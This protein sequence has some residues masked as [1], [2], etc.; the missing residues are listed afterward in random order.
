MS[1]DWLYTAISWILLSWHGVW[2]AAGTGANWSWILAI[3]F[4]VVTLR[5]VLF[6]LFM[7]SIKSQRA[8]Q[9]LAPQITEL[10]AKH[11]SD[12]ETLQREVMA[13]YRKEKANPLGGCLPML[14]QAP[15]FISLY[16]VLNFLNA[17]K[18]DVKYKVLYGWS[19]PQ[20][21]GAVDARLFGAPIAAKFRSSAEDL[22][23]MNAS[24]MT[25]QIVVG[26][27]ALVM[28]ATTYLTTKQMILK[29]GWAAE[30]QQRMIQKLML[31]GFPASLL[32][33]GAIFPLG[34]IIYWVVN[35]LFSLGQQ[36]WVL[37]KYPPLN[38]N[39]QGEV[40]AAAKA[41]PSEAAKALA[42]KPGARP[43][44]PKKNAGKR[45]G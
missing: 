24:S 37:K 43:A 2:D 11:K 18:T 8:M 31:Y 41:P 26:A 17:S 13:L 15:V 14:I 32:I 16:H 40:V 23:L 38:L 42:P 44:N 22:A 28:V 10:R 35:N 1:L 25:V 33:S 30:P 7:K 21:E 12:P 20:F 6:P 45:K 4:V 5:I 19:L 34:V 9:A 36:Q 3:I 29:T 39:K 27:L